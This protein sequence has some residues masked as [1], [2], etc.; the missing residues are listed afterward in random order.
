MTA[1]NK[2][3]FDCVAMKHAAQRR[4]ARETKG[5]TPEQLREYLNNRV[6]KG[7]FARLWS[8]LSQPAGK[9]TTKRA[10]D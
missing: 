6:E 8:R 7:P 10:R 9:S 1:T 2:K 4:I 5:M 3:E